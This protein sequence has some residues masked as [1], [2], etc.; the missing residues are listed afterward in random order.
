MCCACMLGLCV[1]LEY[2]CVRWG[3]GGCVYVLCLCICASGGGGGG[4]E[5]VVFMAFKLVIYSS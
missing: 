5:G 4:G 3:G 1:A 2:L